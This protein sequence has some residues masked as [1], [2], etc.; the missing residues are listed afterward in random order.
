MEG[1][2]FIIVVEGKYIELF[3]RVGIGVFFAEGRIVI[4]K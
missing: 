4:N 1:M 2:F 3:C